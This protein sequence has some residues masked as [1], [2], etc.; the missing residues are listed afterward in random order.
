ML[1]TCRVPEL[2]VYVEFLRHTLREFTE[3]RLAENRP[4]TLQEIEMIVGKAIT[5]YQLTKSI[6]CVKAID[7]SLLGPSLKLDDISVTVEGQVKFNPLI[8]KKFLQK[9]VREGGFCLK[10]GKKA[11]REKRQLY[12]E[13]FIDCS[14]RKQ[15][16]STSY[17]S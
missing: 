10:K 12:Y 3:W 1:G 7:N 17:S 6:Y 2:T 5:A 4:F 9:I 13:E 14:S 11:L 15:F 8:G 16:K